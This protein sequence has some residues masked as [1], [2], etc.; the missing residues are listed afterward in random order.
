MASPQICEG[1]S[2]EVCAGRGRCLR[3]QRGR[4]S[5]Q[6]GAQLG[7]TRGIRPGFSLVLP[8]IGHRSSAEFQKPVDRHDLASAGLEGDHTPASSPAIAH[9]VVGSPDVDYT[10]VVTHQKPFP[11][12]RL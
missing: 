9:P 1:R 8:G 7:N 10:E 11:E 5:G 4:V 6:L 3:H 2:Y 12:P